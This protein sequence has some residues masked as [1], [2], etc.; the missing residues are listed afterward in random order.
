[1]EK[2]ILENKGNSRMVGQTTSLEDANRL[3]EQYEMQGFSV[4]IVKRK[5]GEIS[6]YEVWASK[7]PDSRVI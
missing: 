7:T 3:A 5:Q 1:M 6:L 4:H 2:P